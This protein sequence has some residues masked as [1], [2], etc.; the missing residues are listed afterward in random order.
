[1]I[2]IVSRRDKAKVLYRAENAQNVRAAVI[3][4]REKG[5]NL[6]GADLGGADLRGARGGP[7][8]LCGLP[9]G[10]ALL[11]LTDAGWQVRVGCWT[12]TPDKL[13]ALIEGDE[14]PEAEGDEQERRRPGLTALVAL[15]RAHIAYVGATEAGGNQ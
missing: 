4:A 12:G 2:E 3:E 9:S 13:E 7:L 6:W 5:A 11:H 14:W 10:T 15:C 8:M 1:M